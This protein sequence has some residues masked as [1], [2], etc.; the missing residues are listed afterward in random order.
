MWKF[1]LFGEDLFFEGFG[2]FV[3]LFCLIKGFFYFVSILVS[4][5]FKYFFCCGDSGIK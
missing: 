5:V 4:V 2:G 3:V 1:G